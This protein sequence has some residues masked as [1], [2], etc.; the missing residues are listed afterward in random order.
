MAP[1]MDAIYGRPNRRRS[2]RSAFQARPPRA[3]LR[4]HCKL[5]VRKQQVQRKGRI[6]L[7]WEIRQPEPRRAAAESVSPWRRP[8]DG[9]DYQ[10]LL[11]TTT[12]QTKDPAYGRKVF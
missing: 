3:S 8:L 4:R 12:K 1:P 11:E 7:G 9:W 5:F 10:A 2:T 6:T